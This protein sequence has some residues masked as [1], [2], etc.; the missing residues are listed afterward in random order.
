MADQKHLTLEQRTVIQ[1]MLSKHKTFTDIGKV[2]GKHPST[3]S[4]EVRGHLV[5]VRSGFRYVSYNAC[6]HRSSCSK[7]HVCTPCHSARRFRKCSS[8]SSCNKFCPDFSEVICPKLMKPPYVC[9]GCRDRYRCKI[10]RHL[11]DAKHAQKEYGRTQ[12]VRLFFCNG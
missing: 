10:Q 12:K 4:K 9:N 11:Y 6:A 3:I 1:E 8:C 5:F 2:L 7:T